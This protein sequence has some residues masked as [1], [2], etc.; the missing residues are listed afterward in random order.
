MPPDDPGRHGGMSLESGSQ[1]LGTQLPALQS[2][3]LPPSL[4]PSKPAEMQG[5]QPRGAGWMEL[6]TQ[7]T[8]LRNPPGEHAAATRSTFRCRATAHG[9]SMACSAHTAGCGRGPGPS[10]LTAQ[11]LWGWTAGSRPQVGAPG[12]WNL[13]L[14]SWCLTLLG[15]P[16]RP[17]LTRAWGQLSPGRQPGSH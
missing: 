4:P 1:A 13:R 11:W 5:R 9:H 15:G 14:D 6:H 7:R 17:F 10:H 12:L 3:G 16:A 2:L 8:R